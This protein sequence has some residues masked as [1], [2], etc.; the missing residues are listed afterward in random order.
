MTTSARQ[1]WDRRFTVGV[2]RPDLRRRSEIAAEHGCSWLGD[3]RGKRILDLGCGTGASSLVLASRGAHVVAVDTSA[4]GITRL[5]EECDARGITTIQPVV[6]DAMEIERLGPFDGVLGLMI[7]HHIEPFQPFVEVLRRSLKP[8]ARGFF[9]ENNAVPLLMW[10]RRNLVGRSWIPRHGDTDE[11]PLSAH[12]IDML[13]RHFQVRIEYPEFY[14]FRLISIYLLRS[15][16]KSGFDRIDALA[17]RMPALR[18]LTY[19]QYIL[20]E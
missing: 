8:G 16:L 20:I 2:E 15:R 5:C 13:R 18:R 10:F 9:W 17:Y 1:F 19:K 6:G 14:F 4:E 3:M 12:E 11:S 7:L